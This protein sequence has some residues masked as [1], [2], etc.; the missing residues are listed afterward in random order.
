MTATGKCVMQ[1][2]PPPPA[3]PVPEE[4]PLL[5]REQ[6]LAQTE[7]R[8]VRENVPEWGGSVYVR[9]VSGAERDRFEAST[10]NQTGGGH[11]LVNFRARFAAM[12]LCDDKGDA[13]FTPA[14]V[15]ALG[16]LSSGGAALDRIFDAGRHLNRMTA[17]DVEELTKNSEGGR[18]GSSGSG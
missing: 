10:Q 8:M 6:I 16:K 13:L 15:E 1:P 18:N 7:V 14:D 2:P 3:E 5:S 4:L 17:E 9:I 11:N 12:V